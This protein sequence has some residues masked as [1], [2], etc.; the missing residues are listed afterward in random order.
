[1]E[2]VKTST[3]L[4]AKIQT[5]ID[6]IDTAFFSGKGK[7]RI[8]EFVFAINNQCKAGETAFVFPDALYDK[9]NNKKI[10]YLG[11][12]P[13]YLD[14]DASEILATI[15]HELCHIYENAYIHIP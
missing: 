9:Q 2:E 6:E 12:N 11:I 13:K 7:E 10:Q 5:I 14:R 1:M 8:P 3:E 15:C 4:Y